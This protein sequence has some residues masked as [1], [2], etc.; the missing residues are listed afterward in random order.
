MKH[1]LFIL[2]SSLFAYTSLSAGNFTVDKLKTRDGGE[3]AIT[4]IKHASLMIE[5]GGHVIQVDP[6]SEYANYATFPKADIILITHEHGDHLDK[7]AIAASEKAGTLIIANE[8]SQKI[9]GKGTVMKNGDKLKPTDYLTI[10]AVPAYNTTPGREKFHPRHRDNGY[11]LTL[12]GTRIYIAGDTEDIPELK[13]LKDIDI[14]FLPVNQPYT[15]TVP[16][17]ANAARMFSPKILYPYHYGDTKISELK[18]ALQGSG[19]E[20]RIREMQ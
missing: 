7:K 17:A 10:E 20:V 2:M 6:V 3:L 8:N 18:E 5:Y 16:Q 1:L 15:M 13:N 19:V 9:I 11:I 4:F 14:A 12:G